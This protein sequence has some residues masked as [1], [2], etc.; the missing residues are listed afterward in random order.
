MSSSQVALK[1][2]EWNQEK[3]LNC[4]DDG[5][6]MQLLSS[7]LIGIYN[8]DPQQLKSLDKE[9]IQSRVI[10]IQHILFLILTK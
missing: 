6:A 5:E 10:E 3:L 2:L 4:N 1:I 8:D 7:Y 9:R